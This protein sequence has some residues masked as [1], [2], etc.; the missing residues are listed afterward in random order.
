[1]EVLTNCCKLFFAAG[2]SKSSASHGNLIFIEIKAHSL[3]EN[4]WST[5]NIL[6]S[7]KVQTNQQLA[8]EW[9]MVTTINMHFLSV[10]F[11]QHT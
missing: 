5:E 3:A 1:M 11:V 2:L 7:Q 8:D 9:N 10:V 4:V 6:L